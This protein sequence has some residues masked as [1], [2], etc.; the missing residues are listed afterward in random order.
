ME[1]GFIGLGLMGAPMAERLICKDTVLHVYDPNPRAVSSLTDL[2]AMAHPSAHAVANAARI[3]FACLPSPEVSEQVADEVAGGSA[4][5]VYVEMS[6]VGRACVERIADRLATRSIMVV[7]A[8]I[9][10][11]PKGAREGGLSI[12]A[13]GSPQAMARTR[14]WLERIG[15]DIFEVHVEP[16][17]GQVMKLVNNLISAAI[18]ASTYETLVLGAKSGL[19]PD[20]MIEVLNASSARNSATLRK[21]PEAILTG[22]FDFGASVRTI[23][24]DV[25]LGIAEAH[26]NDVPMWVGENILQLWRFAKTQGYSDRD[27]TTLIQIMEIWGGAVVRSRSKP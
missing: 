1:L 24:K 17:R 3:V 15:K 2:G 19:D 25:E 5:E 23:T 4:V 20:V 22:S 18:M 26:N 10:G 21:V 12:M 27:Y 11:G 13:A 9:S 8:P 7:D 16:G 14:P 6:T